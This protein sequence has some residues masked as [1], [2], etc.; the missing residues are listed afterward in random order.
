MENAH[1]FIES[2]VQRESFNAQPTGYIS[3]RSFESA[4]V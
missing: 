4:Q 2:N 3:E 1:V